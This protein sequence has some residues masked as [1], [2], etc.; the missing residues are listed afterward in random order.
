MEL[1]EKIF[2]TLTGKYKHYC[3]EWDG[4]AIDENMP[5]FDAC[6]CYNRVGT[7]EE[8]QEWLQTVRKTEF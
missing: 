4:M 3:I 1:E 2:Q 7:H 8:Q 6:L 5:E